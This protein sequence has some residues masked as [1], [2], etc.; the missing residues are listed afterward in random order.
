MK[1]QITLTLLAAFFS[2]SLLAAD[3]KVGVISMGKLSDEAPQAIFLGKKLQEMA[4]KPTDE[5][6]AQNEELEKLGKKIEK[7]KLMASPTQVEKMKR[8]FQKKAITFRQN[9]A[10]L[11]RDIQKAQANASSVFGEAVVRVV[12][13]IAKDG[14][15]DLVLHE[16]VIFASDKI[17]IT[18]IVLK[19]LKANFDEQKAEMEKNPNKDKK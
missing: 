14:K 19:E 13:K 17:N 8:E 7:D 12:N 11:N 16:G 2:S 6:K 9:E 4:K 5:L 10:A 18:D 3:L 1:K 15:Y